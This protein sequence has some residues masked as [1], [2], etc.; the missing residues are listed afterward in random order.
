MYFKHGTGNK[1]YELSNYCAVTK[2]DLLKLVPTQG[3]LNDESAL[4]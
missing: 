4:N 1:L 2:Y 3:L